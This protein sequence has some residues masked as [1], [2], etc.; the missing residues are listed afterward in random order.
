MSAG[1]ISG[2]EPGPLSGARYDGFEPNHFHCHWSPLLVRCSGSG[3]QSLPRFRVHLDIN[4]RNSQYN[5]HDEALECCSRNSINGLIA[6]RIAQFRK[7]QSLSFD[8]LAARSDISKGM[9]VAIEQ[10]TANPSI[11]TLCK[12]A[13]TLRVSLSELLGRSNK[14]RALYKLS[15]RIKPTTCGAAQRVGLQRSWWA[16]RGRTCWSFGMGAFPGEEFQ[17]RRAIPKVR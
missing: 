13:A 9:L 5:D 10:G 11:G 4:D 12:L 6:R 14:S 1:A 15:R 16:V 7:G 17:F 8:A 2:S 3:W